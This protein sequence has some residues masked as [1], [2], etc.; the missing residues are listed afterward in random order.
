MKPMMDNIRLALIIFHVLITIFLFYNLHP[1]SSRVANA[2]KTENQI[3]SII[4]FINNVFRISLYHSSCIIAIWYSRRYAAGMIRATGILLIGEFLEILTA[5]IQHMVES[6]LIPASELVFDVI[7][8]WLF[9]GAIILTYQLAKKIS[10]YHKDLMHLE[11]LT[12]AASDISMD[13]RG[14]FSLI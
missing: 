4:A 13:N 2:P 14:E 6:H 10:N 12:I 5:V 7:Y 9:V 11:L 8:V 3:S 1:H